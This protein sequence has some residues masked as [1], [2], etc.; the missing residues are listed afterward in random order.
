[1]FFFEDL[2]GLPG[3]LSRQKKGDFHL[4]YFCK[5]KYFEMNF[6]FCLDRRSTEN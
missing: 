2:I 6:Y 4:K 3:L 1:M 5:F